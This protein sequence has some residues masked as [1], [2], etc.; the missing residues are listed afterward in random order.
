MKTLKQI[1]KSMKHIL[2]LI[3]FRIKLIYNWVVI[4]IKGK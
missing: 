1:L 4:T 3:W 2:N